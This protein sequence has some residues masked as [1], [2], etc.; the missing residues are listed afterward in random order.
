MKITHWKSHDDIRAEQIK[1]QIEVKRAFLLDQQREIGEFSKQNHFLEEIK[2]DYTNYHKYIS[3]QKREQIDAMQLLS[4]YI[5]D[6]TVSGELSK[7]NM[8]DARQ[9]QKKILGEIDTIKQNLDSIIGK[10]QV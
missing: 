1:K 3:D 8:V 4:K 10:A 5:N 6:L 2:K 7:Q 9:E